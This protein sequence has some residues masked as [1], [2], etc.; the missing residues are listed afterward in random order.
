MRFMMLP[1]PWEQVT[2]TLVD[3]GHEEVSDLDQAQFLVF[4][5]GPDDL[6]EL[7]ENLEFIHTAYAGMDALWQAGK[8]DA[9]VRWA[10]AGGLYA[11]SVAESTL[12]LMI[13]ASHLY[14][15]VTK[16]ATWKT[17][18]LA[19]RETRFVY[20][21]STVLIVGAGGIARRLIAMLEPFGCR[22]I[23]VNRS[24]RPVPGAHTT[25]PF[26]QLDEQWSEADFVVLLAPLTG[27]TRHLVD[28]QVLKRMRPDS[29]LINAGRGGLVD[30]DALVDALRSGQIAGAGLDVTEPEP[31]PDGHP[32]WELDNCLITPHTANTRPVMRAELGGLVVR[33]AELFAAGEKMLTEVDVER[34]Y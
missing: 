10:N 2:T 28:A 5:G 27:E 34:A 23:A 8:L 14:K 9:R 31:L 26:S 15:L 16:A 21:D 7:P 11:D 6:P 22:I 17:E 30:T 25:L 18:P 24:G 12:G 1:K 32:L 4:N 29:Y 33:N 19:Q 3:A 20:R 13:G